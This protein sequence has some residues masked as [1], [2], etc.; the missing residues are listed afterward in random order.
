MRPTYMAKGIN[1]L[2]EGLA[3]ATERGSKTLF[4][5]GHGLRPIGMVHEGTIEELGSVWRRGPV[6]A[7]ELALRS[8]IPATNDDM[9]LYRQVVSPVFI[10]GTESTDYAF[11]LKTPAKLLNDLNEQ[12]GI[13]ED[14]Y[15]NIGKWGVELAFG[16]PPLVREKPNAT[17]LHTVSETN[18]ETTPAQPAEVPALMS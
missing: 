17:I 18:P 9:R 12:L 7:G 2:S 3:E 11:A 8:V 13:K 6:V 14:Y 15:V 4:I 1:S 10:A 16:D 5:P